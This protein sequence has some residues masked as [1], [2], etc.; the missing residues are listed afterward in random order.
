MLNCWYITWPVGFKRLKYVGSN[1]KV[2]GVVLH[3]EN[4]PDSFWVPTN[5]MYGGYRWLFPGV[6]EPIN[7]PG[8]K[9]D[10]SFPCMDI[11]YLLLGRYIQIF[12]FVWRC[13]PTR[14]MSSS[15]TRF[16]DHTQ[17]RTTEGR[18]PLDEWSACRWDLYL[19]THNSQQTN[20]HASGGVR[21]QNISRR[22]VAVP[23]LRPR[24]Y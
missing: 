22:A 23:R 17:R 15:F 4:G 24:G 1:V 8:C 19:M 7:L 5:A 9:P 2:G 3:C 6:W 13:G 10:H 21:T 18:S 12:F 16:L 11:D 20:I 14:A